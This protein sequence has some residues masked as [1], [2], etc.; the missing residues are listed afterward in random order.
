[1]YTTAVPTA[2]DRKLTPEHEEIVKATLP[3]VGANIATIAQTFYR[4]VVSK[5]GIL[6]NKK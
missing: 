6:K 1:M 5:I 2:R 4:S 3:A